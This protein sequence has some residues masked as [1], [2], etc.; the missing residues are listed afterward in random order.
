MTLPRLLRFC[1][2]PVKLGVDGFADEL[3]H[4]VVAN[5]RLDPLTLLVSQANLRF[6]HVQRRA[7]HP[8]GDIANDSFCQFR[9]RLV[10]TR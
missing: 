6:F 7:S 1:L 5:N 3:R 9:P 8:W 10:L 2:A 4:A